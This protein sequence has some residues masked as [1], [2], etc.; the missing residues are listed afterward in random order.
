MAE[1][2]NI[3]ILTTADMSPWLNGLIERYNATLSETLFK[4]MEDKEIDIKT[5]LCWAINVKNNLTN[6]HGFSPAQLALGQ[7]PQLPCAMNNKPPAFEDATQEV[8][9]KHLIWHLHLLKPRKC[10]N[11]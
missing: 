9:R 2:M 3:R 11:A 10:L 5:A 7:N 8:V 1:Q 6:V 4:V